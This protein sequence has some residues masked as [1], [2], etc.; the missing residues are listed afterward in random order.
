MQIREEVIERIRQDNDIVDII[1]ENVRLKKSGRNYV[2][3]CPFHNDK[4]PSLSVSQ[5]KQIYK[6]FSCGEAGN[7]ITFV[8]KYK[9]L[10]FYEASKYL[11]DK[12]GIPLELGNAKESQ[13][14]KKKE[15][16]YKVNTE[17][18]RYYFYNL[19]RTSFAKEYFLKRGIREEVIK[20][21]GLGYAQ[22]RWHDLIMYL[23]KKGFNENLLLEAGLI[24]KSEKKGNTYDR[25]RNRVMFP[26][27][28]VRG[29]VIG[30]GGRV[31]DDSKPKY[32]NSPE[33]VV[34]HKGTNLY[35]LNFA[36]KNKLEQDYIIIVEG[37]MDLISLHQH[38]ITNTVASLGTALTINQARLLK[39]YVNKVIISYDADVAG[40]TATLRGL[41]ILRH[42]GLDV[43]VLKVPQGKD[44]DEFVRNNGKDAFLRLVDNA[45]PLIEYRI[46]KAAE[47][48]NLRDNNELVKYGEK[49]AEILADLNPIEKDVY[50]KKISE[51]TSIK[52]QAI[53]DLLSQVMAKDQKE[54]NFM[55]KKADYGTKLYV[56][57]G[58]LKAER[59]LIKLMF[60]E[61]YFQELNELIKVGDFVLDSHNK[62]YSLI[63]QGKNEDTSNIISY[64]ESRCDDVESSKELINIKEQEILE[65][66]DKDRV[67]KDYMQ[68]VQSYKLKKKIED[69][70][71]KQSILEKEGKFQETIEIAMELTR[72]TKS[73][74][75]GE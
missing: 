49:F 71:K 62:I 66:T 10:T 45:L 65:F 61:E 72:L 26:V 23:K 4:S 74:K 38:G 51:E 16:L 28:D 44:P 21:F 40:Q 18:A 6:C 5:D 48:I 27:F 8:M 46:K 70:K 55:N 30:F 32:L 56:E 33:T 7:V 36:T 1:S 52:E 17:A 11:A 31:L 2:G 64:L 34:F 47:G 3:L 73:L 60:K 19:Q 42:A 53:Y 57:P 39:R 29:K 24:L 13:I 67:I 63:L 22:D 14:T 68:E 75:R 69:L 54:N 37:Y 43:K 58:Y 25:F 59:T 20:R 15:L 41:E 50:I 9:K 12:A 35:G